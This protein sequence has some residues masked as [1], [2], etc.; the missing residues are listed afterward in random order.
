MESSSNL[1]IR[2][3]FG[4][5]VLTKTQKKDGLRR[6][7][8]LLKPH[9]LTFSDVVSH[10][11]HFFDLFHSCPHGIILSMEG[12]VLPEFEST[13][14]LK[15]KDLISVKRKEARSFDAN[16]AIEKTEPSIEVDIVETEP[17]L[18]QFKLLANEEFNE[19]AG[20]YQIETDKDEHEA[21][22]STSH[23]K[24]YRNGDLVSKKRKA[25]S[26]L[27]NSKKKRKRESVV[28][29][30]PK[31]HLHRRE[32]ITKPQKKRKHENKSNEN[33]LPCSGIANKHTNDLK[34]ASNPESEL[35]QNKEDT[36]QAPGTSDGP[37]KVGRYRR[38]SRSSRRKRKQRIIKRSLREKDNMDEQSDKQPGKDTTANTGSKKDIVANGTQQSDE[39]S[40][41]DG[42]LVPV[43]VRPGLIRFT[44]SGKVKDVQEAN[45]LD[46]H[47]TQNGTWEKLSAQ[48]EAS[49]VAKEANG[50]NGITSKRKGQKWG[51]E[52][53]PSSWDAV[54]EP[55]SSWKNATNANG[56]SSSAWAAKKYPQRMKIDFDKLIPLIDSPKAGDVVAYRLLELSSSWCPELSSF[57]VGKITSFEPESDKVT[58]IPVPEYPFNIEKKAYDE[59]NSAGQP[60]G[61]AV[62]N[63]D[64]SLETDFTSLND[65]RIVKLGDLTSSVGTKIPSSNGSSSAPSTS[66]RVNV[67]DDATM[68]AA[69]EISNPEPHTASPANGKKDA[70]EEIAEALTAKK[71]QLK[72]EDNWN[73]KTTPVKRPWSFRSVRSGAVGPVMARLR[74]Q[75]GR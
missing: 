38:A 7:W 45:G 52:K 40:D 21:E 29:P 9:F 42:D 67:A 6:S 66:T 68:N 14:I 37:K 36:A 8:L 22:K 65:V 55:S 73:K 27:E 61:F 31:K 28:I 10:I 18:T 57:R 46:V 23:E 35:Q 64:G 41:A 58:L 59:N 56:Q 69:S 43:V 51:Q 2:L 4:N 50:W 53:Q 25:S 30:V 3:L 12:F 32:H 24:N 75:N 48:N 33:P 34:P 17:I 47:S 15:D 49:D 1:R 44:R 5:G 72:Q 20:G 11:L 39:D 70:W 60:T 54:N 19:E 63:N 16:K 71:A 26:K 62:Y 74:D 13:S